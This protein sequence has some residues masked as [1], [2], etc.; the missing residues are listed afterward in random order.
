[1]R[2]RSVWL[3]L[4]ALAACRPDEGATPR[5]SEGIVTEA[6]AT[7]AIVVVPRPGTRPDAKTPL[8][9]V[10]PTTDPKSAEGARRVVEQ[11]GSLIQLGRWDEARQMW[12]SADAAGSFERKLRVNQ[13]THIEAGEPR[14]EEGAAGSIYVIVP[15][16]VH[17]GAVS[18]LLSRMK[19]N[20]ILRRVNDVPGSTEAQ[21][22]WHIERVD[23]ED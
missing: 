10:E 18:G 15:I 6:N 1:M 2:L 19:A 9:P 17:S 5:S 21:R 4:L 7:H 11:F 23:W 3:A 16:I 8:A 12:S 13:V 14:E 22:R 20:V